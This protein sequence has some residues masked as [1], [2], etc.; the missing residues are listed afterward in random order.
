MFRS[1]IRC[2]RVHDV[3]YKCD[4]G[5]SKRKYKNYNS[6]ERMLRNSTAWKY[7]SLEMREKANFLCEVCKDH[8]V[9]NYDGL[10]VHHIDKIKDEPTKLLDDDN[11]IVLCSYHH[12]VA[13]LGILDKSY[14][15]ELVGKRLE[16]E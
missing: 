10:E 8:G 1:C 6:D 7:K 15:L 14:L 4:V 12:K 2:G 3:K 5:K 13:D 16:K 11:L 9:Y